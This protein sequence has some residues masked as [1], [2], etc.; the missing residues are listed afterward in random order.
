MDDGGGNARG[1]RCGSAFDLVDTVGRVWSLGLRPPSGVPAGY[2]WCS[3][4]H[5]IDEGN[6]PRM[7]AVEVPLTGVTGYGLRDR[8]H[9]IHDVPMHMQLSLVTPS[10]DRHRESR[11][12]L[13]GLSQYVVV[14]SLVEVS[15]ARI[16][17]P[18]AAAHTGFVCCCLLEVLDEEGIPAMEAIRVPVMGVT[19]RGLRTILNRDHDVPVLMELTLITASLDRSVAS[20]RDAIDVDQWVTVDSL[21]EVRLSPGYAAESTSEGVE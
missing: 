5:V 17:G 18:A 15:F 1:P 7:V 19:G 13:I 10:L 8:L 12:R 11:R 20:R 2:V 21:V 9:L 16:P 14:D 6:V 3:L 4:L